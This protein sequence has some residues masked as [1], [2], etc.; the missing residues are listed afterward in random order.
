MRY[1]CAIIKRP[2]GPYAFVLGSDGKIH[3]A[4]M[5]SDSENTYMDLKETQV[6]MAWIEFRDGTEPVTMEDADSLDIVFMQ[7]TDSNIVTLSREDVDV[8]VENIRDRGEL[9]LVLEELFENTDLYD[10]K[11]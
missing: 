5:I 9:G 10:E 4:K 8:T 3:D 11:S 2:N 1:K 6:A 7:I